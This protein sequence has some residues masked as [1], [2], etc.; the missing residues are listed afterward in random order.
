MDVTDRIEATSQTSATSLLLQR[1]AAGD[2]SARHALFEQFYP[3]LRRLAHARLRDHRDASLLQTTSLVHE[4]YLRVA[5][6]WTRAEDRAQFLAYAARI[7][8][9]II[10]DAARTR[11]CDRRGAGALHVPFDTERQD[12]IHAGATEILRVHEA[13]LALESADPRAARIVEMRYFAGYDEREIALALGVT[14]RTV[15]RGWSKARALL[16]EALLD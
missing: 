5:G 8:R 13:V 12:R 7:M 14:E 11:L 1:C 10:A 2:E 3:A 9:S 15:Q 4:A 16:A 6:H